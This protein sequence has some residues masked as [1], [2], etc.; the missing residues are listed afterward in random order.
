[1]LLEHTLIQLYLFRERMRTIEIMNEM[2]KGLSD[3]DLR[4]F[5]DFIATLP[6]PQPPSD[7]SD[8]SRMQRAQILAQQNHCGFCHNPDFAGAIMCRASPISARIIC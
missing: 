8:P 7:G 6:K 5:S 3:D 1:L 4:K 2:T